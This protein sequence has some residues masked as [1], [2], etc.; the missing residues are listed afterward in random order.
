[1]PELPEVETVCRGITSFIAEQ[2]IQSVRQNRPDL[3]WP[4]PDLISCLAGPSANLLCYFGRPTRRGKYILAPVFTKS[5]TPDTAAP[6]PSAVKQGDLLIHLGM[7]GTLRMETDSAPEWGTHDHVAFQLGHGGWLVFRDPRRFG[8]ID[9]IEAKTN[10][11]HWLLADMG[12]EPL[13]DRFDAAYLSQAIKTRKSPIKN[14]LL[15]QHLVAGIGNIYASEALF[16]AGIS[17]KRMGSSVA[18]KRAAGLVPAIKSV[19]EEAIE[20]GGTSL[21]D[22][23]QPDGDLGYFVQK[24]DVYGREGAPCHQCQAPIRLIRQSGRAS[25]YCASCQR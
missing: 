23:R 1:M 17:P 3:R 5:V 8:H 14:L 10:A 25:Y 6:A 21:R 7:S 16:R 18:G 9:W 24:L 22:H 4:M 2:P 11:P 15:D 20:Q 12:P 19:L 13:S